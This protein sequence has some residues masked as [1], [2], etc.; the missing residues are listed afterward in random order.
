MQKCPSC[1]NFF[2]DVLIWKRRKCPF[3]KH[4]LIPESEPPKTDYSPESEIAFENEE[5]RIEED[6]F[7]EVLQEEPIYRLLDKGEHLLLTGEKFS[8]FLYVTGLALVIFLLVPN[9]GYI[10]LAAVACQI[11]DFLALASSPNIYFTDSRIIIK[12]K[13]ST[14]SIKYDGVA[15]ITHYYKGGLKQ[16]DLVIELF[17]GKRYFLDRIANGPEIEDFYK[18][19][20]LNLRLHSYR[21]IEPNVDPHFENEIAPNYDISQIPIDECPA[22]GASVNMNDKICPSCGISFIEY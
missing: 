3:C 22:C 20:Q 2:N 19:N 8:G 12:D 1:G 10:F 18:K 5:F 7:E 21:P 14:S 15:S 11:I 9:T 16:S 4:L 13:Y 6:L 17:N